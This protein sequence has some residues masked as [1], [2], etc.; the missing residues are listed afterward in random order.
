MNLKKTE[1]LKFNK[2]YINLNKK[3]RGIKINEF[4]IIKKYLIN[5][6]KDIIRN[7]ESKISFIRGNISNYASLQ[8]DL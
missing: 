3:T 7:I 6:M 5:F 2:Y 8:F 4:K 1:N